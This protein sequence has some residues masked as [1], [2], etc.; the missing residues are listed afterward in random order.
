MKK[1]MILLIAMSTL[2]APAN[3]AEAGKLRDLA[4]TA[5]EVAKAGALFTRCSLK[6][7]F[8]RIM[9]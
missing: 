8:G 4:L 2:A 3:A 6:G 7:T 1:L 5:M 9:C